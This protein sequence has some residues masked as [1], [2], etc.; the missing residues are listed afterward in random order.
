M[1]DPLFDGDDAANTPLEPAGRDDLIPTYIATRAELNAAEQENIS[2]ADR[3]AFSRRRDV[4]D[5]AFLMNLHR[6]MLRRVWRWAGARRATD[7]NI[8]LPPHQIEVALHPL[9]GDA[10]YWVENGTYPEDEL[11][12]RFHHRLVEIHPFPNGNGRH[13]RMAA[14]LLIV[15]LGG[16]RFS[17]G[18]ANLVEPAATRGA[19]VQPLQAAD[20][21]DIVPLLAFARS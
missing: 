13:G 14:D 17:W 1:S 16:A 19:Y 4:L 2:E 9:V 7:R 21:L 20:G 3:W 11:A 8:G 15:Q 18:G 12:L 6:R 10:R 5:V